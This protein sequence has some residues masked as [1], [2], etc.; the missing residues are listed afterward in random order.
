MQSPET[1]HF[2][3]SVDFGIE[4]MV[5][6]TSP[7]S[8]DGSGNG[9]VA[10]T[11]G[12]PHAWIMINALRQEFGDFPIIQEDPEPSSVFWKR[13]LRLLGPLKVA[14]MQAARIPLKLTKRGTDEIID[15]MIADD[16]LEAEP[17]NTADIITVPSVNS[18]V[19]R[20]ELERL[21][22]KAVFVVSTRMISKA[23]LASVQAPIINYHSGINPAYRGMYGG[24]FALANGEPEHFGATVHLVDQGVDTGDVLYQSRVEIR[25]EDNFHTYLWRMASGSRQIVVQAM[26]DALSGDLKPHKV[27]LPSKQYFAP[28]LGGYLWTG[29]TRGVW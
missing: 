3:R 13:R 5:I 22:P 14:S 11:S 6:E 9:L 27:D 17:Q 16:R 19:C 21:A 7:S 29:I 28:T 10:L 25:P 24:Y 8:A 23:T 12:G 20:S 26:K 15:R 2:V 1:L 18:D 4:I